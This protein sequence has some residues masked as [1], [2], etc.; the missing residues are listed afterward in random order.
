MT[1]K[2]KSPRAKAITLE[3]VKKEKEEAKVEQEKKRIASRSTRDI[4]G[5]NI[6][7]I[8]RLACYAAKATNRAHAEVGMSTVYRSIDK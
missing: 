8:I 5:K 2:E 4:S 3:E 7:D 6:C 1:D